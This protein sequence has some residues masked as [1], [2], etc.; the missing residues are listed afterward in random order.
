LLV[1]RIFPI[2]ALL[3]ASPY[4]RIARLGATADFHHGLLAGSAALITQERT[5]FVSSL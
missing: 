2:F 4:G 3:V 5:T 1:A